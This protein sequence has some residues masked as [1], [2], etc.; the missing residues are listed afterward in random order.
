MGSEAV[1]LS[2]R[3]LLSAGPGGRVRSMQGTGHG[4]RPGTAAVCDQAHGFSV[5]KSTHQVCG[6]HLHQVPGRV[7]T[8]KVTIPACLAPFP[9]EVFLS[10]V[11]IV[12]GSSFLLKTTP[13]CG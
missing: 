5:C 10:F 7:S 2:E 1:T 12:V 13:L 6:S 3:Q 4:P 11:H 8:L 9:G